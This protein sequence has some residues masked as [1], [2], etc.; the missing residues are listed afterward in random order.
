MVVR[1]GRHFIA[2]FCGAVLLVA[3]LLPAFNAL[4]DPYDVFH[5]WQAA[6]LNGEKTERLTRGGRLEKSLRLRNEPFETVLV[7]SSRVLVGMDPKSPYL[8]QRKAYN[9]GLGGT[10]MYELARVLD[11]IAQYQPD[12]EQLIIGLDFPMF[13]DHRTVNG[14]YEVSGFAGRST[15]QLYSY[16]LFSQAASL[17]S[18]HTLAANLGGEQDPVRRDGYQEAPP[19]HVLD[20]GSRQAFAAVLDQYRTDS[21]TYAGLAKDRDY[22]EDRL[23]MLRDALIE[24]SSR[25]IEIKIFLSPIHV[26]LIETMDRMGIAALYEQWKRDLVAMVDEINVTYE[27]AMPIQVWDFGDY[28]TITTEEVPGPGQAAQMRWYWEP[29]HYRS[30]V[31][32]L[33]LARMLDDGGADLPEDFGVLLTPQTVDRQSRRM[34]AAQAAYRATHAADIDTLVARRSTEVLASEGAPA[35]TARW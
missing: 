8:K 15:W 29:S 27:P 9:A 33:M 13:N 5:L 4:V 35:T 24:A 16:L 23:D 34:R 1:S 26:L 7:G 11:F 25:G 19:L 14:D 17:D 28:N 30:A 22:D 21:E 20:P 10:N 3:L 2:G 6:G 18:L 32:D 12:L 31:S